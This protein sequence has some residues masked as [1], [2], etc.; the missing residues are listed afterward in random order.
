MPRKKVPDKSA[1]E[2]ELRDAVR[3][4]YLKDKLQLTVNFARQAVEEKLKL[5][6]GF[7][8]QG[9]W[10]LQSKEVIHDALVSFLGGA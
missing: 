4:I 7:F 10:K 1:L 3:R 2:K 8:R 9:D 5:E 6:D